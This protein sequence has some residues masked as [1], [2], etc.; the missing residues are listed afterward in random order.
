MES[1]SGGVIGLSERGPGHAVFHALFTQ[2]GMLRSRGRLA[3][4][5][6]VS[7][8]TE[9]GRR[10]YDGA[11]GEIAVGELLTKLDSGWTVLHSVPV[12]RHGSDIDHVLLGPAGV[13]TV[14]TKNHSGQ[15]IWVGGGTLLVSGTRCDHV[16]N[17]EYEA[18]RASRLL[19]S[20]VG[21]PVPVRPV[22]AI[23]DPALLQIVQK[24]TGV[25]VIDARKLVKWL[26]RRPTVLDVNQRAEVAAV[27]ATPAT[28]RQ[29]PDT[30]AD[31]NRS[32][33][34]QTL[35]TADRQARRRRRTIAVLT[36]MIICATVLTAYELIKPLQLV[37]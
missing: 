16:R 13:F 18:S 30:E 22:L 35:Q 36:F 26:K 21:W 3:Q 14:N 6:G 31:L 28:W 33:A 19:T 24:P 8:L 23:L 5:F 1:M 32:Q 27:L 29:Q 9:A 17:S 34:F 15:R 11:L 20:S 12:G 7:P 2:P 4:F 37:P 25:D 10:W